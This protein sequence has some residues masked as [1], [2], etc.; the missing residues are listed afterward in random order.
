MGQPRSASQS[1][2]EGVSDFYTYHLGCTGSGGM[3]FE[4]HGVV[5]PEWIDTHN[6]SA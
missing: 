2:L 4:H 5:R 3:E 1:T 6:K